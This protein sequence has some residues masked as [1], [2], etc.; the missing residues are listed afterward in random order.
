MKNS[1]NRNITEEILDHILDI[2]SGECQITEE[3]ILKEKDKDLQL[4]MSGLLHLHED[5]QFQISALKKN[6]ELEKLNNQLRIKN[7]EME[8]FAYIASHDLQEPVRTISNFAKLLNTSYTGKFDETAD[9]S[10]RFMIEASDRMSGL[11]KG[12]LDYSRIGRELHLKTVDCNELLGTLQEDLSSLLEESNTKL[13]VKN[14][15]SVLANPTELRLVFQN[16]INNAIKFRKRD[17]TPEVEISARKL[18]D[19]W[20]FACKDNG[21]GIDEKHHQRIFHIFQRLHNR[22]EYDG[23]GIG[24]SHCRKIVELLG[25]EIWVDSYPNEGSTFYFTLPNEQE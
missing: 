15:P 18:K 2:T 20:R 5:I 25:G 23:T 22:N 3:M 14:L 13:V 17:C 21:I 11:I 6:E 9:K 1:S 7:Y 16:L 24:L 8:Q 10:L 19:H 12:L 4:I